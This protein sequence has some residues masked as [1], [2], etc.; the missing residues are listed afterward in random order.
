METLEKTHF[1]RRLKNKGGLNPAGSTLDSFPVEDPASVENELAAESTNESAPGDDSGNSAKSN[2]S[3]D[4]ILKAEIPA[5]PPVDEPESVPEVDGIQ[6]LVELE[7]ISYEA[8]LKV[9]P[10]FV[11]HLEKLCSTE[12][13][14]KIRKQKKIVEEWQASFAKAKDRVGAYQLQA[15]GIKSELEGHKK[16]YKTAVRTGSEDEVTSIHEKMKKAN[17]R[18]SDVSEKLKCLTKPDLVKEV[19]QQ[20][21]IE[22][23]ILSR[24]FAQAVW[25]VR[26]L[27][28]KE[29]LAKLQSLILSMIGY[30]SIMSKFAQDNL[31]SPN[32]YCKLRIREDCKKLLSEKTWREFDNILNTFA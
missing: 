2:L 4:A 22:T 11:K 31:A 15:D 27:V 12:I 19:E 21:R 7:F 25:P 20:L 26:Q 6:P 24:E 30:E 16:D 18:L 14:P 28:V 23:G 5:E 1:L 32:R 29:R 13:S 10:K 9:D 8:A 17:Q 3:D